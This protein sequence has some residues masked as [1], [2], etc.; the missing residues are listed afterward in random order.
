M[1]K[2]WLAGVSRILY[3]RDS[4]KLGDAFRQPLFY[5]ALAGV[6]VF[7]VDAWLRREQEIVRV[8]DGVRRE[9]ASEFTAAAS[10]APTKD[11]LERGGANLDRHRAVVPG[12]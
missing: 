4:V 7:G 5:F 8:T 3:D 10:R 9:V 2:L 11:E 1:S 12:S 6:A